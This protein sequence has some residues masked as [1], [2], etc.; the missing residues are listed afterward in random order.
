M[1][2]YSTIIE[3]SAKN[4]AIKRDETMSSGKAEQ[5]LNQKEKQIAILKG[6][7]RLAEFMDLPE[8][9]FQ[10]LIKKNK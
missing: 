6:R 1:N 3:L 9:D 5:V 10:K 2:E 7:M 4:S 8:Y